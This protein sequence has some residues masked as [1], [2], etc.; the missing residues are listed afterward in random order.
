MFDIIQALSRGGP[1]THTE[2]IST[3]IYV[4]AFEQFDTSFAAAVAVMV[5]IILTI[6]VIYA[7]RRIEVGRT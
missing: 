1:G 4:K 6:L 7:L 3:F 2:T 5:V